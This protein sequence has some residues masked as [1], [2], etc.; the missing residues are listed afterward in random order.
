MTI[1]S[2]DVTFSHLFPGSKTRT[3]QEKASADVPVSLDDAD[4]TDDYSRAMW[5]WEAVDD[6]GGGRILFPPRIITFGQQVEYDLTGAY[7]IEVIGYGAKLR[8][9]VS[10]ISALRLSGTDSLYRTRIVGLTVEDNNGD[11]KA[12]FEQQGTDNV[13]WIG[14]S[15]STNTDDLALAE[16]TT[17][18]CWYLHQTDVEVSNTGCFRTQWPGCVVR[19]SGTGYLPIAALLEGACNSSDFSGFV[20]GGAVD[21]IVLCNPPGTLNYLSND[22]KVIECTLESITGTA[23]RVIGESGQRLPSGLVVRPM[24]LETIATVASLEG[25]TLPAFELP[26]LIL[27]H[28]EA[29]VTTLLNNPNGLT[30]GK[31]ELASA[32]RSEQVHHTSNAGA[33][34]EALT[35]SNDVLTVKAGSTGSGI[36]GTRGTTQLWRIFEAGSGIVDVLGNWAGGIFLHLRH[37][38][39]ISGN[40]TRCRNL[41]GYVTTNGSGV[42]AVS[43]ANAETNGGYLPIACAIDNVARTAACD[44]RTT[45]GFNIYGHPNTTYAWWIFRS[46]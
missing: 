45:T 46:G 4:E 32:T 10:D 37:V 18:A 12:G 42:G 41:G 6:A 30:I 23:F 21:G 33:I 40:D 29:D 44:D 20:I 11:A 22:V 17:Y 14:C 39:G 26:Q 27:S 13:S 1:D 28:I 24:R 9:S 15:V 7:P 43:L 8:T 36:R 35:N 5:A 31:L 2:S 38:G 16:N 25:C 19:R 34:V 3:M